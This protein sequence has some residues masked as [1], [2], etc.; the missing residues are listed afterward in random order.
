MV[1]KLA[2]TDSIDLS[3]LGPDGEERPK[4]WD[5]RDLNYYVPYVYILVLEALQMRTWHVHEK[6]G[7]SGGACGRSSSRTLGDTGKQ[8][9]T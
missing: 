2:V 4:S 5:T 9:K 1:C 6:E 7:Y 3:R 8:R